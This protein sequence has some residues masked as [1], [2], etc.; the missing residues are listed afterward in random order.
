MQYLYNPTKERKAKEIEIFN[1]MPHETYEEAL[2]FIETI[3]A[4]RQKCN[5]YDKMIFVCEK[6]IKFYTDWTKELEYRLHI[7]KDFKES[8]VGKLIERFIN[9]RD[10]SFDD[11]EKEINSSG[12]PF[13]IVIIKK[14]QREYNPAG[15]SVKSIGTFYSLDNFDIDK[16]IE[17][18]QKSF[19]D[20]IRTLNF[21]INKKKEIESEG[22]NTKWSYEYDHDYERDVWHYNQ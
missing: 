15:F 1:S 10:I 21:Y 17:N 6:E 8:T 19:N 5:Q 12:N 16:D 18:L 7:A 9:N 13:N 2:A 11:I 3:D 20:N 14:S 4:F 22:I